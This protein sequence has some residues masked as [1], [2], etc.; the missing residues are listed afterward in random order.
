LREL[1]LSDREDP[2]TLTVAK[3]I[4]DLANQGERGTQIF[5]PTKAIF[6]IDHFHQQ[7]ISQPFSAARLIGRL[8]SGGAPELRLAV[9][10]V[11][12]E[13]A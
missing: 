7:L 6:V 12:D 8:S 11:E 9:E 3:R 2:V 5:R 1:Q 13:A 10:R 4:I